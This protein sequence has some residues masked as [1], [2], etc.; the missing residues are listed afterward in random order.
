MT[1]E[2]VKIQLEKISKID[3]NW[4]IELDGKTSP[5]PSKLT[6]NIANDIINYLTEKNLFPSEID[7]DV[8]GGICI[9]YENTTND[10]QIS[11][12][13]LN[14]RKTLIKYRILTLKNTKYEIFSENTIGN[15]VRFLRNEI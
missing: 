7:L 5:I 1:S 11:I 14:N 15:I 10:K 12:S 8:L 4:S 2:E 13:I 3:E 9:E 6:I